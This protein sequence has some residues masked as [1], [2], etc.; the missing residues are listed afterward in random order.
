MSH[1]SQQLNMICLPLR[2]FMKDTATKWFFI[3]LWAFIDCNSRW[4]LYTFCCPGTL[5]WSFITRL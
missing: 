1:I 4:Q 2:I 3:H 5:K